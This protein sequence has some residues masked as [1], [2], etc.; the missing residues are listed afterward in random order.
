MITKRWRQQRPSV[1]SFL[2]NIH[3]HML[4][5]GGGATIN[6]HRKRSLSFAF[7]SLEYLIIRSSSIVVL[8]HLSPRV[9]SPLSRI[10]LYKANTRFPSLSRLFSE[11]FLVV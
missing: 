1:G 9:L 2:R 6:G 4:V 3:T 11:R 8:T 10:T 7:S 5:V